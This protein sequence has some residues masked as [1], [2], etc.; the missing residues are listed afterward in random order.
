MP[1][2]LQRAFGIA[3]I[4]LIALALAYTV[5]VALG[6]RYGIDRLLFPQVPL[7]DATHESSSLSARDP[8]G[9]EVL[10]RIYGKLGIGCV[11]FFP[12]QHGG[13]TRY[14]RTLFPYLFQHGIRVLAV[15]YP[16]Q[17]GAAGRTSLGNLM[18]LVTQALRNASAQCNS[19]NTV[20]VGRSLGA[21]VAAYAAPALKP[22]GLVL[23]GAAPSL[24]AAIRDYAKPRYFLSPIAALPVAALLGEDFFLST[25]LASL[26]QVPVIVFQGTND[27][28]TPLATL[29]GSGLPA[30]VKIVAVEGGSHSDT[31]TIALDRYIHTIMSM[32]A[33]HE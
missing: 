26:P 2:M 17:D 5:T 19:A 12:G 32:L 30:T 33:P 28:Q 6:L 7:A 11:V 31:Y 8:N 25:A 3:V 13:I 14:E 22:V 9:N 1:L 24:S 29:A 23:E 18:S 21:M 16:G 20:V 10:V 27:S 4:V 15:S